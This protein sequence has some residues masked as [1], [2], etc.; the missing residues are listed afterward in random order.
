M[1]LWLRGLLSAWAAGLTCYAITHNAL[2]MS[3]R[4]F[5]N[6]QA[7]AA[8]VVDALVAAGA[9]V[10]ATDAEG[11]TPLHSAA[12][13]GSLPLASCLLGH[14]ADPSAKDDKG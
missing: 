7:E 1:G 8:R 5:S 13:A 4:V 11:G 14:G 12:V 3:M 10:A 2:P 6:P 9:S